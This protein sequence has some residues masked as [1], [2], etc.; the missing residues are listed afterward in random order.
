MSEISSLARNWTSKYAA[1]IAPL[2]LTILLCGPVSDATAAGDVL[3]IVAPDQ[4]N[5]PPDLGPGVRSLTLDLDP[6]GLPT[7]TQQLSSFFAYDPGFTGGVRVAAGD[8]TGDGTPDIITGAGPGGGPH[9]KVFDA[10][11][12]AEQ[13]NLPFT[14]NNEPAFQGGVFVASG[15]VNNDGFA[16]IITGAG[17]GGGPPRESVF[18]ARTTASCKNFSPMTPTSPAAYSSRPA[19]STTTGSP[20][21]SPAPAPAKTRR[22]PDSPPR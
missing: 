20:T 1:A 2:T 5:D 7:D 11:T 6:A 22:N 21:S 19:T 17:A 16:D 15:D 10:R 8:V 13:L 4:E 3:I 14:F 18:Q 9:V 12:G